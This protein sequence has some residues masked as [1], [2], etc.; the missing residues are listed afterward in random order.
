MKASGSWSLL[1]KVFLYIVSYIVTTKSSWDV[2]IF[3][4]IF[5]I[6]VKFLF[7]VVE[8]TANRVDTVTRGSFV[9]LG[10]QSEDV[11]LLK[12][13]G[14][15]LTCVTH[16]LK[17]GLLYGIN[18]YSSHFDEWISSCRLADS[19]SILNISRLG[20]FVEWLLNL[21]IISRSLWL[22]YGEGILF[23]FIVVA[24]FK[25]VSQVASSSP[26][27]Q[28][29]VEYINESVAHLVDT[30]PVLVLQWCQVLRQLK[31]MDSHF[32]CGFLD[33]GSRLSTG[34]KNRS[35]IQWVFICGIWIKVLLLQSHQI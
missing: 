30:H 9:D 5:Q 27:I 18:N 1:K 21:V 7:H 12:L 16:L 33:T 17:S 8:L 25:K 6:L 22:I 15:I 4:F 10:S 19:K 3:F 28:P 2:Y 34:K 35:S 14:C 23:F 13:F 31:Y 29:S 24:N 20:A 26:I 32:W 11:F